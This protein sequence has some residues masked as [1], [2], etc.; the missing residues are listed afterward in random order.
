MSYLHTAQRVFK[1]VATS[2]SFLSRLSTLA[3]IH[4]K[5]ANKRCHLLVHFF[6]SPY[7]HHFTPGRPSP[8][9]QTP[10]R[11][12]ANRSDQ[13]R[14]PRRRR[15]RGSGKEKHTKQEKQMKRESTQTRTIAAAGE[16]PHNAAF[17]IRKRLPNYVIGG[18]LLPC[19]ILHTHAPASV[20][21]RGRQTSWP[22]PQRRKR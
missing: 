20:A 18:E 2:F 15:T 6:F 13:N 19:R 7:A 10:V 9:A 14:R 3:F 5:H 22:P 4:S 1:R 21:V 8:I 17:T 11:R 16:A 12:A